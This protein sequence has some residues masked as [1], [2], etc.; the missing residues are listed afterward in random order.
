MELL[1]KSQYEELKKLSREF[2]FELLI[3]FGSRATKHFHNNSDWDFAY[4][5]KESLNYEEWVDFS[6][7]LS[8]IIDSQ[9]ID[10][11]DIEKTYDPLLIKEIFIKGICLYES[12]ANLFDEEQNKAWLAYLDFEP[13]YKL[14]DEI[15]NERLN[16]LTNK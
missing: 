3:L 5:R 6:S 9:S 4:K 16:R 8:L 14:Q 13:N 7:K 10:I 2:N 1:S 12:E 11:V 15:I